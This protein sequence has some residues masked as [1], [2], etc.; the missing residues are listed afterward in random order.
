MVKR[1]AALAAC[2][3]CLGAAVRAQTV[4]GNLQGTVRDP[5]GAVVPGATVSIRNVQ[6]GNERTLTTNGEGFYVATFLPIGN[7]HVTASG[8]GFGSVRRE[9]VEVPLNE[10]VLADFTLS[11]TVGETVTVST[12]EEPINTTNA[13]IKGRLTEQ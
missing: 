7:Y 3:L 4:T 9:G 13:E 1:L 11:P 8:Q 2:I 5:N 10:T 12:S 6:T